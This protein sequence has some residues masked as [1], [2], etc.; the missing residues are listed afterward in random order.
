MK[1]RVHTIW[2]ILASLVIAQF[3]CRPQQPFYLREDGDLSHY[4]GVATEI[5]YPEVEASTLAD[6]TEALPPYTLENMDIASYWD[7][8]L[9]ETIQTALC[10]SKVFRSLGGRFVSSAF[11]N[12]AQTGEAPDAITLGADQV[13][14][15]YDPAIV[16]T[17]PF[18]G[19]ENAL[20]AFDAQWSSNFFYQH[21]DRQQNVLPAGV[22]TDFFRQVFVQNTST[23]NT[24]LTKVTAQGGQFSVRNNIVYDINNNP[25]RQVAKDWNV[26]YEFGFNQPLL[27]G[28]GTEFNRIAGPTNPFTQIPGGAP[29]SPG[30]DGVVL[31]RINVDISLADFEGGVRDLV[32][33]TEQAYWELS[34]AWRNL[35]TANTALNSARQTWQK[36]HV[37][38]RIGSRGGEAK[39]EAQAREQFY[40][41]KSQAQ[42]LANEL[43]RAENRLRY[44]MGLAENDGR[45]IRP[46]DRPTIAEV[47]FDW[48][49]ITE[50]ALAR[51]LNLRRQKWRIK[52]AELQLIAA[53]NLVLP[54]LDLNG[55]YRWLGLGDNLFGRRD[56]EFSPA[57]P[58]SLTGSSALQTLASGQF[59]E[60]QLG[61]QS[62]MTI[63]LRREL[64][65][66]RHFQL[67]LARARARLQDMELEIS[68]QLADSVRQLVLN[69]EL[70]QTN[71]NRT[72]AADRQVDAVQ[73][74]FD[75]ATVT[76]DQLLEAQRRRAEAQTS[77]FRTLLDYQRAII[78][79]H[80]RKGSLLE[81]NNVYLQEGPWPDK[82]GF[83]AHRLARQ[84][85]AGIYLN[86]GFTRPAVVSQGAI[87][88]NPEGAPPILGA[89]GMLPDGAPHEAPLPEE[90]PTPEADET[91]PVPD[92][93]GNGAT[94]RGTGGGVEATG[95][96]TLVRQFEW[97][98]LGLS[99]DED[100]SHDDTWSRIVGQS[101]GASRPTR[102]VLKQ[103]RGKSAGES[104]ARV[105]GAATKGDQP[106]RRVKHQETHPAWTSTPA[107]ESV[108]NQPA[109]ATSWSAASGQ[110]P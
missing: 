43:F 75:A 38:Y 41:F 97:G 39:E 79:V 96:S 84:R 93:Y 85:D 58:L 3:G 108:P 7:L 67:Q 25:T 9:E 51:N 95:S 32:N 83:D 55:T 13:R 109:G 73:A 103:P 66:V 56:F 31:A 87:R 60:W 26:N 71:F 90:L 44:V 16:E 98:P 30:F 69:Y 5:D 33:D 40:Q 48:C 86:Y 50:E 81:Y 104:P 53:K 77:F 1:R 35:E 23:F 110:G 11:N 8:T 29:Q 20:S 10:N 63:G 89:P 12:R 100:E 106:V 76:L 24:Q 36:I 2:A 28:A 68:H 6:V 101:D 45:L 57:D 78:T 15:I 91:L 102:S 47:D 27:A 64:A 107:H 80:F 4:L 19:V 52:E 94:R 21:N 42:T 22:V 88:Q 82:A 61:F 92:N 105:Q 46:I 70:T 37:L 34:F 62:T 14:T 49:E 17:T 74:A 65:T 99:S 18:T 59:Q 72:L 54:R